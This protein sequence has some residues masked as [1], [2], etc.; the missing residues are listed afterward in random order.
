MPKEI[1]CHITQ[2]SPLYNE[3]F[4]K[5][6]YE[7]LRKPVTSFV[8]RSKLPSW[9][10]QEEDIVKDIIQETVL[11]VYKKFLAAPD[12]VFSIQ[13][14]EAFA[15]TIAYRYFLDLLRK[16]KRLLPLPRDQYEFEMV[17]MT[18]SEDED[19]DM[20]LE[21]I[22]VP[23]VLIDAAHIIAKIP[24]KQRR[25]LLVDLARYNDFTEEPTLMEQAFAQVGIQLRDYCQLLPLDNSERLRHNSLVSQGY[26]RLRSDFQANS[27]DQHVAGSVSA[28]YPKKMAREAL[29][30]G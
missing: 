28:L 11:R 19:L 17:T 2:V 16:E 3:S 14:M 20:I 22:T 24:N 23:S 6:L 5:N 30:C 1:T 10:G 21:A 29:S 15:Y 4:W 12:E 9:I 25:A 27:D 8:R 18:V 13:S 7:I 26:R